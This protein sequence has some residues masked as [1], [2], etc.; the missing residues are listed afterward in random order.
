MKSERKKK[1]IK[2]ACLIIFSIILLIILVAVIIL[3]KMSVSMGV[4]SAPV[5]DYDK[6]VEIW[7]NVP[8][9]SAEKKLAHMNV[10]ENRN[11]FLS[12]LLFANAIVNTKY[13]D[14]ER[15]IDTF[16][17]LYEVKGGYEKE[18]YED[19]PYLIPYIA[20]GS[21]C[22]VIVLPGGGFSFKSMD[23]SD[24]ESKDVAV[25]LQENGINAFVLHYRSNPYEYPIPQL[26]LQRAVRYLRHHA[27]EYGINPNKIG[28]IGFSAGGF[29]VASFINQIQGNSLFT[30]GY[31]P[32]E[33]DSEKDD[34]AAAAMI[35]P[36]VS[37]NNNVPMLFALFDA[38]EVKDDQKRKELLELVD[39][40]N[41]VD[42]SKDIP[43]FI[44]WGTKDTM[45]GITET[46]VYIE[47]AKE[48]GADV[49]E[50]IV[51]GQG[52]GFGQEYYMKDF[53]EW[54]NY[55]VHNE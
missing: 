1:I 11:V 7:N 17:Y 9:S 46:H 23:G 52:H 31:V 51:D 50:I 30:E 38:D 53:L 5:A 2:R 29:E 20:G 45:V 47:K 42:N 10:K 25:A 22:A 24:G 34:I 6:R 32:D 28:L 36:A 4:G 41:Y 49:T 3:C 14:E 40:K 43:Q 54:Y 55:A 16:T 19:K 8:G 35:Y 26:D 48:V 15:T 21:D 33:I 12:Q 18:T 13:K 27:E 39:M 37:F 44:A